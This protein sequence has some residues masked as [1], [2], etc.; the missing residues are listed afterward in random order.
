MRII[1][2]WGMTET[3]PL[4]SVAWP[5][6]GRRGRRALALPVHRRAPGSPRRGA[7]RRRRRQRGALG[8][9]VDRRARG[10]RPVDRARVLPRRRERRQVQR[11]LASHR[12]HRRDRRA[13]LHHDQRP[14]QGRDQ[15]R[16]R[17]DLLGRAGERD[18]GPPGGAGGGGDRRAARAL[19]RAPAGLRGARGRRRSLTLDEL[20]ASTSPTGWPSGGSPTS[21]PSSTP[22]PRPASGKF[23]KKVLRKDSRRAGSPRRASRPLLKPPSGAP[24]SRPRRASSSRPRSAGSAWP[25]SGRCPR[26]PS[27]RR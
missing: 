20:Q 3:S 15:V 16:R 23:D 8:R 11:R 19:G 25:R 24:G 7:H 21:W 5:P 6:D 4:G 9:Q 17:V 2:A 13:R 10:A 27:S 14:R 1:Q 12:R 18:H 22:S 26:C